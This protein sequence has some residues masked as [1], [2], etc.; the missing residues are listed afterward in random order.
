MKSKRYKPLVLTWLLISLASWWTAADRTSGYEIDVHEDMTTL[1]SARS[2][3]D[4]YL[5]NLGVNPAITRKWQNCCS[6]DG[7]R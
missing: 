7:E 3:V 4:R 1:A 2:N 5:E 6:V